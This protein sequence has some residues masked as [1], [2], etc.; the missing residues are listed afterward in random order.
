MTQNLSYHASMS[1]GRTMK[2]SE[3]IAG[4]SHALEL[5]EDQPHGYL[6]RC[7]W[8]GVNIGMAA[9]LSPKD[10]E[11]LY[12][13]LLLKD[14]GCSSTSA[15][16]CEL[17]LTDD[18][19]FKQD[20]KS[21]ETGMGAALR[22]I[23]S[24][25]GAGASFTE[26]FRALVNLASKG[27]TLIREMLETRCDR[28]ADIACRLRFD[29]DVQNAIRG[30]D[31]HWNGGGQ[32][33]GL[34]KNQIH[35]GARIALLSQVI[36]IFH[37]QRGREGAIAE[38]KARSGTWFDP[39]LVSIF[40]K[41]SE[42]EDFWAP[43]SDADIDAHL[44]R[45]D[46]AVSSI[47]ADDDYLDDIAG[48]FADVVDAKSP[49]TAGHSN[50][51]TDYADMIAAQMRFSKDHRRWLRRAALLH[52][53]G[54]L[55]VSNQILDKPG[56]LTD[57]EW[58]AVRAHPAHSRDIL[59]HITIFSDLAPVAGAHHERLDGK[60]YPDGRHAD[61]ITLE[62]RI[63][64]VADVFDALTAHR[65][66]RAALPVGKALDILER[67]SGTAFDA[68]CV[69]ALNRGLAELGNSGVTQAA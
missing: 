45:L 59:S 48:G 32:P 47:E 37:T 60:G 7:C 63:L 8:I 16:I 23:V 21:L 22:F 40:L 34:E 39:N 66:Y 11:N 36:D 4:L 62:M 31:E 43:L 49:Y 41:L 9:G 18:I 56:K 15:R 24:K 61:E 55:A 46:P 50:R 67:D 68:D 14:L 57:E 2:L 64:T 26:R 10:L 42:R 44:A 12:Y 19:S 28:G 35:L 6:K 30:L 17:F 20:F 53:V 29:D 33:V 69:A 52:D 58:L 1:E 3:L 13:T 5:T 65:P 38:A 54:K 25:T 51:V 27:D